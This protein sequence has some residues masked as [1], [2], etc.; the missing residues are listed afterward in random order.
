VNENKPTKRS[1]VGIASVVA[2]ATVISKVFGLVRQQVIAAAFGV[3]AVANAYGNA[4]VIPGFLLVLLGGINGPFHSAMVSILAKRQKEDVA[5][6]VETVSTL[7]T[8]ALLIISVVLIIFADF[9]TDLVVPGLG[10]T[11][12][13]KL[14]RA[15]AIQQLQIMAPMAILSGLIG[16]GFGTL[17]A[18]DQYWLPAISPLLSSL[19]VIVGLGIFAWQVGDRINTPAYFQ[20]GGI[21]LASSTLAGAILQWLVQLW[22]Q[23]RSNLGKI[24]LR[25]DWRQPGVK[26]AF[27]IML[28]ATFSSGML[29]INVLTDLY[30]ASFIPSAAAV[31]GYAGLLVN[32]PLGIISNIILVPL[33]PLFSKLAVP[34]SWPDLKDRI[35]QGMILTGLTMLPIS[36]LMITLAIPIVRIIYERQ[37][38]DYNASQMVAPVLVAYGVGM[39]VYL[40]R[41]VLLR[42]FYALEDGDTP[43]KISV[44]NIFLNGFLDLILYRPLGTVGIVLATVG[45]NLVSMLIFLYLLDRRLNGLPMGEWMSPL[46]GITFASIVCG[47]VSWGVS[48]GS[49]QIWGDRTLWEQLLGLG[50]ASCLG[51]GAFFLIAM[52]LNLP[53]LDILVAR[54]KQKLSRS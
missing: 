52:R 41:D 11:P 34:E 42:V 29:Q 47:L 23:W 25:F 44:F 24:K 46:G 1:S 20:M 22:A 8:L 26:E 21:I 45:V 39:F 30:F 54:I 4:Y 32:T 53:E 40:G 36:A 51:L 9:F 50:L 38:F 7:V 3:G 14:E 49:G 48:W 15:I 27:G 33:M 43:F 35:R 19:S 31:L 13:G 28:P 17:N 5:P 2:V 6:V 18:A 37:A 12:E 10:S 16:I